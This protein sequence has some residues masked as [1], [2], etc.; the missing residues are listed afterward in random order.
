M[1]NKQTQLQKEKAV[2]KLI[3]EKYKKCVGDELC[4]NK[5]K[6]VEEFSPLALKCICKECIN[7]IKLRNRKIKIDNDENYYFKEKIRA[8]LYR[9]GVFSVLRC[10]EDFFYKW[11]KFQSKDSFNEHFDHVLPISFFKQFENS[12]M[13]TFLRDSW[14][15]ISPVNSTDNL[16]KGTNVDFDLFEK[17]LIKAEKFILDNHENKESLLIYLNF[18]KSIFYNLKIIR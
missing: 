4:C 9:I 8:H 15:N 18:I 3:K 17:Q 2:Q 10:S 13:N 12:S 5:I 11:I 14:I 16:K 7:K 1:N 6:S